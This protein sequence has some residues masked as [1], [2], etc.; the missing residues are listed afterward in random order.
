[1]TASNDP[2]TS[3]SWSGA[4]RDPVCWMSYHLVL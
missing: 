3:K 1:M 4:I 2:S